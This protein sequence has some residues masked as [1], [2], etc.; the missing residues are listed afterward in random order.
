[1]S[2]HAVIVSDCTMNL[3]IISS[4][5]QTCTDVRTFSWNCE[6]ERKC[7]IRN[8]SWTCQPPS[9]I[10]R[11]LLDALV[12]ANK[13]SA[14]RTGTIVMSHLLPCSAPQDVFP[15][16]V[17][18][19]HSDRL[20]AGFVMCERQSPENA[21]TQFF[22]HFPEVM[23]ENSFRMFPSARRER[24]ETEDKIL[25]NDILSTWFIPIVS[26]GVLDTGSV[27][28]HYDFWTLHVCKVRLQ[29]YHFVVSRRKH[30]SYNE[31]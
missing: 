7:C 27:V 15:L 6:W 26:R 5:F 8:F 16:G 31:K 2:L 21:R 24:L 28:L 3:G 22:W 25:S 23:P 14:F 17:N 9:Q 20:Y 4:C 19:C 12:A 13:N 11:I 29:W 18:K 1:M 10:S 30:T